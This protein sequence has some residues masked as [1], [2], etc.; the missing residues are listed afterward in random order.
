MLYFF[1]SNDPTYK[2]KEVAYDKA[3]K[4]LR[5]SI[6]ALIAC[7]E[8]NK[9]YMSTVK[10][11]VNSNYNYIT[12][13]LKHVGDE[14]DLAYREYEIF[15]KTEKNEVKQ[16]DK[17]RRSEKKQYNKQEQT[18][19]TR[20]P[21]FNFTMPS[22]SLFN[23]N[24]FND[25]VYD[26]FY[27][28]HPKE[29]LQFF[30]ILNKLR[31]IKFREDMFKKLKEMFSKHHR[32]ILDTIKEET[33]KKQEAEAR[34]LE[35]MRRTYGSGSAVGVDSEAWRTGGKRK[36][37]KKQ[38]YNIKKGRRTFHNTRHRKSS[39]Y[40]MGG[41]DVSI[42]DV[43]T[44]KESEV[45][46]PSQLINRDYEIWKISIKI[47]INAD[48]RT[49]CETYITSYEVAKKEW[50]NAKSELVKVTPPQSESPPTQVENEVPPSQ[51]APPPTQPEEAEVSSHSE[52]PPTKPEE[53]NSAESPT[54]P[55]E[56][57][58]SSQSESPRTQ[59]TNWFRDRFK[60][61]SVPIINE[62]TAKKQEADDQL[63][64]AMRRTYGSGSAV[65]VD[66]DAWRTGGK[67]KSKKKQ[68]YNIKKGRRTFHNTRHRKSSYYMMG[69]GGC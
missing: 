57:V 25:E 11:H 54:Q 37:K 5:E 26:L 46:H 64:E 38:Y 21:L 22:L 47:G 62:D 63:K 17:S 28:E 55:E 10:A 23:K 36:S 4:N 56:A 52:S 50:D 16:W 61:I 14:Y 51:S 42:Y 9:N 45:T 33:A 31:D 20:F 27:K 58:V 41:V 7:I 2:S 43:V 69:G 60:N 48:N 59:V 15:L 12:E 34:F 24:S 13:R 65:G 18:D 66:S 8:F 68:Y 44:E 39:Y 35:A 49:N 19:K 1:K 3:N 40:M 29:K 30:Q 32:F 6:Q 67:R 53:A